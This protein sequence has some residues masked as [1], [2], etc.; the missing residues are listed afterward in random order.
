MYHPLSNLFFFLHKTLPMFWPIILSIV[1]HFCLNASHPLQSTLLLAIN[2]DLELS[3]VP[4][5]DIG[6]SSIN[7]SYFK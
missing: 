4:V 1:I 7:E 2:S 5:R 3:D 6:T